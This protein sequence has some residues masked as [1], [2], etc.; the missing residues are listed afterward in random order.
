LGP[1]VYRGKV[2]PSIAPLGFLVHEEPPIGFTI[3]ISG[4]EYSE[5]G[6]LLE[7]V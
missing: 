7:S 2:F 6:F 4:K 1:G 5:G 3:L